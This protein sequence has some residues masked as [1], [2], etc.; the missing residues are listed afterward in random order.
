MEFLKQSPTSETICGE[1]LQTISERNLETIST[2]IFEA[3]LNKS[4]ESLKES[5]RAVLLILSIWLFRSLDHFL[6]I[7]I[8]LRSHSIAIQTTRSS[9][10]IFFRWIEE[11][12]H[13][14]DFYQSNKSSCHYLLLKKSSFTS[15]R[16][17]SKND[18]NQFCVTIKLLSTLLWWQV[19]N[20]YLLCVIITRT[21]SHRSYAA[22]HRFTMAAFSEYTE[23]S[24][25][26]HYF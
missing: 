5:I 20:C 11:K 25:Y 1:I 24:I 13:S 2:G 17:P 22:Y 15:H 7:T 21:L 19:A 26:V 14:I 3:I 18:D 9:T 12:F 8:L 23:T 6:L 10:A 16:K 4:R